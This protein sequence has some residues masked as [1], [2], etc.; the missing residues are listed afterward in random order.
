MVRLIKRSLDRVMPSRNPNEE[1]FQTILTEVEFIVNSRPLSYI[2][3]D[4]ENSEAITPNHLLL[5]YSSGVKPLTHASD[6]QEILRNSWKKSLQIG[7]H[8]WKRFV[9][10]VLPTLLN[11]EKWRDPEREVKVGDLVLVIDEK[12]NKCEYPK[13]RVIQVHPSGT[14]GIIRKATIQTESGILFFLIL[15]LN[16]T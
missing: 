16:L 13:A 14:D 8:Y 4:I 7:D 5:G 1:L 10:E 2:P 12:N 3:I 6:D 11:R 9:K 15:K